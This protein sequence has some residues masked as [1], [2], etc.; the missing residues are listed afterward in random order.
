LKI[1]FRA[2]TVMPL[3]KTPEICDIMPIYAIG[4][5]SYAVGLVRRSA[6]PASQKEKIC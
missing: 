6:L 2:I 5:I 1:D 4:G 3:A